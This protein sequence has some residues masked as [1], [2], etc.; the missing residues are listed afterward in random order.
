MA[1]I[2]VI[3]FLKDFVDS[4]IY[5]IQGK[6]L[7]FLRQ[8]AQQ[9]TLFTNPILNAIRILI[10]APFSLALTPMV[11][12]NF[13]SKKKNKLLLI[14]TL[15][16]LL[17]RLLSDG[18]RSPFIYLILSFLICFSYS[19]SSD[20]IG[21]QRNLNNDKRFHLTK[22]N[23]YFAVFLVICASG[24]FLMT[25]SR[26][27]AD[28]LRHTYLYFAMEPIMLQKWNEIVD[29]SQLLGYGMASGN[30]CLFPL[31]YILINSIGKVLGIDYPKYWRSIYDMIEAVGTNWQIITNVGTPANSYASIFWT[32]YLDGRMLGII[33][34]M[35]IYGFVVGCVYQKAI[36]NPSERNLSVYCLVLI[37]VFYS[38]QQF[39]FENI[40]YSI[41]FLMLIT[42]MY[43]KGKN[44]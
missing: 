37:G 18:G 31:F 13:F 20:V 4:F 27:G 41:A 8:R 19:N 7:S 26:S 39:I 17:E 42:F 38:F 36:K 15:V 24:L 5:L 29:E 30:G 28:S 16:I 32:F 23:I 33:I 44:M 22:R 14:A 3:F 2:T 25:L 21:K 12:A 40:Y 11:A 35:F 43:T 1:I 10:A 9:G 6:S 34:G